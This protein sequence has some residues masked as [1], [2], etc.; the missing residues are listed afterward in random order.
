M[1]ITVI[2]A[3]WNAVAT[4]GDVIDSLRRQQLPVGV[5]LEHIIVDGGSTDGTADVIRKFADEVA[6]LRWISERDNGMYDALNKGICMATG[7]VIG[8]CNSDDVLANDD[9]VAKI[10]TAFETDATLDATYADIRFVEK[11][12]AGVEAVRAAK[13]RRYCTGKWFRPWMFRFG[14]QVAHP[15]F[16]CRKACFE[17][18]GAYSLKYGMFG[19][20]ELL[21]RFMWKARIRSRY[22]PLCTHV[23]RL[24][25][26]STKSLGATVKIN[27][28][29]L[30]ALRDNGCYSN[31]LFL[32][33]R[34]PFKIW[35][36]I[37]PQ[38]EV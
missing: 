27:A 23:M 17:R 38:R 22:L 15:S 8:I 28:S 12:V 14:T 30:R 20:F 3:C 24:D 2:T 9:V 19:D 11:E 29:N 25:G 21:L 37:F 6:G 4:I 32:Y 33:S 7:D 1:K 35:G 10:A 18:L 31:L 13:T 36:F 5:E 26:A 34:Y 16:F